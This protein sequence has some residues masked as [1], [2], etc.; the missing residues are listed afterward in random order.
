VQEIWLGGVS[1]VPPNPKLSRAARRS[2]RWVPYVQ[3]D[4]LVEALQAYRVQSNAQIWA[5]EITDSSSPIQHS[6]TIIPDVP[7]IL[8]VGAERHGVSAAILQIVDDCYHIDMFGRNS[9]LN[10]ATALGIALYELTR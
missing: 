9:S 4:N 7:V 5:L 1:P 8:V 2:E 3:K 6:P 10:V